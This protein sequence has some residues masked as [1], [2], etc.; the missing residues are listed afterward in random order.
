M[1]ILL[2]NAVRRDE[3]SRSDAVLVERVRDEAT[4][5]F[6]MFGGDEN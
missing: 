3:K 5:H 6:Y 1:S 2:H 4:T